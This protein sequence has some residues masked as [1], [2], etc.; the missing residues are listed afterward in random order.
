MAGLKAIARCVLI[1]VAAAGSACADSPAKMVRIAADGSVLWSTHLASERAHEALLV[2]DQILYVGR[3]GC[4]SNPLDHAV[5]ASSGALADPAYP[6]RGVV[7][8]S[9]DLVLVTDSHVLTGFDID[10]GEERWALQAKPERPFDRQLRADLGGDVLVIYDVSEVGASR[11]YGIDSATGSEV[12]G[13]DYAGFVDPTGADATRVVAIER[14]ER[15]PDVLHVLDRA[16]GVTHWTSTGDGSYARNG[17]QVAVVYDRQLQVFDLETGTV[18][19]Q[20]NEVFGA[21]LGDDV[22]ITA[23]VPA[24]GDP[25]IDPQWV[26]RG[27]ETGDE[28]WRIP[29]PR[30]VSLRD[31]GLFVGDVMVFFEFVPN[32]ADQIVTGMEVNTGKV[33]WTVNAGPM[34]RAELSG[35]PGG[36]LVYGQT[37]E[38]DCPS[39]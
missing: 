38:F 18:L 19:W 22:I 21:K 31:A 10:S 14:L 24:G 2:G 29:A 37:Q 27:I 12:W 23:E 30:A 35:V 6:A 36:L 15:E 9:E 5:A 28:L 8:A 20:R 17:Q 1:V 16:T 13:H 33:R 11:V 4:G 34:V 7:A 3:D 39:T 25:D 32:G 26:G